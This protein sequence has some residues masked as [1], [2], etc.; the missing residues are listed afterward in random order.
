LR[1]N[2][3]KISHYLRVQTDPVHKITDLARGMTDHLRL[4]SHH[5]RVTAGPPHMPTDLGRKI[6][7]PGTDAAICVG[8]PG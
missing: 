6:T 7:D 8:L 2:F 3:I 4:I 1:G 5:C